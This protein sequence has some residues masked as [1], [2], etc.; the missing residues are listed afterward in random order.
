[1]KQTLKQFTCIAWDRN[2]AKIQHASGSTAIY[3]KKVFTWVI[4]LSWAVCVLIYRLSGMAFERGRSQDT[5]TRCSRYGRVH[6]M[7][8]GVIFSLAIA[9]LN[10]TPRPIR[11]TRPYLEH[12]VL[13]RCDDIYATPSAPVVRL[14][15]KLDDLPLFMFSQVP[16]CWTMSQV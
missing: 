7:G 3:I 1:M 6:R 13:L 14:H 15:A 11:W 4:I 8:L 2:F 9:R 5:I 12:I 16:R 10:I